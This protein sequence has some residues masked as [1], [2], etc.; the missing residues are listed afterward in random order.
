[1][2]GKEFYHRIGI[3]IENPVKIME[4]KNTTI[5]IKNSIDRFK[6]RLDMVEIRIT[7]V[8]KWKI[9][10]YNKWRTSLESQK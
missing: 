5:E 7:R 3:S 6:T 2:K 10:K 9:L 4:I 8:L 1:M